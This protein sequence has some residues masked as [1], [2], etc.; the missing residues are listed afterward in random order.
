MGT[1]NFFDP[2]KKICTITYP[3]THNFFILN[4]FFKNN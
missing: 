4:K 2:F 3:A 1:S